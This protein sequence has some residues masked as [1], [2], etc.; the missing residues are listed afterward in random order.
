MNQ[1]RQAVEHLEEATTRNTLLVGE[2]TGAAGRLRGQAA[3]WPA[4]R[5]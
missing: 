2:N 3:R 1:I 4:Q 5:R